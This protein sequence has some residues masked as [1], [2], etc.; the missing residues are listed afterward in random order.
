MNRQK[1]DRN[2]KEVSIK[3]LLSVKSI[4]TQALFK[5]YSQVCGQ[6]IYIYKCHILKHIKGHTLMYV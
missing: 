5:R 2:K 3:N 4:G 1:C 6:S